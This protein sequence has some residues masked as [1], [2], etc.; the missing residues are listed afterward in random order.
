MISKWFH[1]KDSAITLRKQGI[2]IKQIEF[3]LGIPRSTLSGWLKNIKLNKRQKQK[4]LK[5]WKGALVKAR[6]K[7]V[8]WHNEQKLNHLKE[9]ET[10]ALDV[11]SKLNTE[12]SSILDLALAMLYLGEG[13]KGTT[14]G[15]GNSD[16]MILKFFI[17]ILIKNYGVPVNK[18]K[19]ELHLRADQNPKKIKAYW[20]K[21]LQL[22]LGNFGAV[23]IDK[24]TIGSVTYPTYKGV[25]I[26]RCGSV[27]ITRKLLYI[28]KIFCQRVIEQRA[29]SSIG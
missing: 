1:L 23:S 29:R 16:P 26:V 21:E 20:S 11:L 13:F 9:A 2:S 10:K 22:P 14:T 27:A 3:R 17:A 15:I 4:L 5:K 6:T 19:C 28:S 24:R 12:N 7:A 25:C 8:L 18:L